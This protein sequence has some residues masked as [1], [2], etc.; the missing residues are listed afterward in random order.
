[1]STADPQLSKSAYR[2]VL[3]LHR[4][5][6]SKDVMARSQLASSTLLTALFKFAVSS[7]MVELLGGSEGEVKIVNVSQEV[8]VEMVCR[9]I[10]MVEAL[11]RCVLLCPVCAFEQQLN[12]HWAAP[13]L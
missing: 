7:Q 1:M 8:K 12:P 13:E 2:A 4:V 9:F 10:A 3:V 11:G 5:N 6:S